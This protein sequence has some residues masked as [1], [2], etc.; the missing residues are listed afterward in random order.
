M[1]DD[2]VKQSNGT[3]TAS[4]LWPFHVLL[5]FFFYRFVILAVN[6]VKST[7]LIRLI[8]WLKQQGLESW[9]NLI[10]KMNGQRCFGDWSLLF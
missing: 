6:C 4:N 5:A 2:V 10:V 7:H 1:G 3:P 9:C 8:G